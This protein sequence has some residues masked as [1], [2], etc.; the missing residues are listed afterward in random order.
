LI[1]YQDIN[2]EPEGPHYRGGADEPTIGLED[3]QPTNNSPD[4][5][6]NTSPRNLFIPPAFHL[7]SNF[8]F[9]PKVTVERIQGPGP[10]DGVQATVFFWSAFI[11]SHARA[12]DFTSAFPSVA[13][14]LQGNI[15][16]RE[17]LY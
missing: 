6:T 11:T 4:V 5:Y 13:Q 8:S 10:L 14:E 2:Y 9:N 16:H 12:G 3:E 7:Y 15:S 17:F 1:D